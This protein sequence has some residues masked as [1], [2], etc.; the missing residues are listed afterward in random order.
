[1]FEPRLINNVNNKNSFNMEIKKMDINILLEGIE[2]DNKQKKEI[3]K[4]VKDIY[5]GKKYEKT[6][7]MNFQPQRFK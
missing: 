6:I 2:L 4:K 3:K 7:K 5:T 1:M